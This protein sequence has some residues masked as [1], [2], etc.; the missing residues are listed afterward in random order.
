MKLLIIVIDTDNNIKFPMV[1]IN[2][3]YI[4]LRMN[5]HSKMIKASTKGII[6]KSV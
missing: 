2:F 1:L 5:L 6:N 4:F 3:Y